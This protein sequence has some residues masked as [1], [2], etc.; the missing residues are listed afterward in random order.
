MKEVTVQQLKEM[1]DAGETFQL[2]DVREPWEVE[3][4]S[5]GADHIPMGEILNRMDEIKTD[6]P[7][8][9][10]CR[11]GARSANVISALEMQKGFTNLYNLKGGI[12]AWANEIDD[13]LEQY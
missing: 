8:I 12:L 2:I 7:V 13:S 6:I 3:I 9:V 1:Q 10:H 11:S 5:I 4:C